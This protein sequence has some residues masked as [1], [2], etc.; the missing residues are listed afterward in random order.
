MK[1]SQ[2]L[3]I[4]VISTSIC[5]AT[6]G[7]VMPVDAAITVY[8]DR[9]AWEAAVGGTFLT[10]DFNA[11]PDGPLQLGINDAG[12]IDIR[13][14]GAIGQMRWSSGGLLGET[15][16]QDGQTQD[17]IFPTPVKAFGGDWGDATT[18]SLLITIVGG[19]TIQ[20]DNYLSGFGDG[21][22][23]VVSTASFTEARISDEGT[24]GNEVYF[25]DNVS[26]SQVPEPGT[27]GVALVALGIG[28][29]GRRR[30]R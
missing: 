15:I 19:E 11:I 9:S 8:T 18:N 2:L 6:A 23:G 27:L 1:L 4:S 14:N 29:L 22:L 13:A 30:R 25:L 17:L 10:E 24:S 21:F 12:L 26:F 7:L 20:F 3:S 16:S 28:R 5:A